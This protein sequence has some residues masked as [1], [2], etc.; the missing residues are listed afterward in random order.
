MWKLYRA[1]C[2]TPAEVGHKFDIS[3]DI[4]C[5]AARRALGA[6]RPAADVD[7]DDV[8]NCQQTQTGVFVCTGLADTR[9]QDKLRPLRAGT[10]TLEPPCDDFSEFLASTK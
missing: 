3:I 9:P 5:L 2:P 7:N 4:A 1:M 6:C 10:C 8:A